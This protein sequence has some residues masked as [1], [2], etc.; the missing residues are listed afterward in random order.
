MSDRLSLIDQAALEQLVR[1]AIEQQS[2]HRQEQQYRDGQLDRVIHPGDLDPVSRHESI[3]PIAERHREEGK[4]VSEIAEQCR[5]Q[6]RDPPVGIA[7]QTIKHLNVEQL[8]DH[9]GNEAC[10]RDTGHEQVEV[11]QCLYPGKAARLKHHRHHVA[12]QQ[13]RQH[14]QRNDAPRLILAEQTHGQIRCQED[15]RETEGTPGGME[16]EQGHRQLHQV[17]A[18]GDDEDVKQ[19]QGD[20]CSL[21]LGRREE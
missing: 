8:T 19:G 20:E 18:G 9:V 21:R 14:D 13:R 12:D 6:R 15:E 2:V 5:R 10:Q 3:G 16:A 17:I 4:G 11:S 7:T 1:E